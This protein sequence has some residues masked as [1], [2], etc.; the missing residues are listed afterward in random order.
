MSGLNNALIGPLEADLGVNISDFESLPQGQLTFAISQN[1][2]DG[3]ND[4]P[5]GMIFLLD[6]GSKKDLLKTNL[7]GL[8]KKWKDSGKTIRTQTIRGV[9]FSIVM[10][11]S[12]DIPGALTRTCSRRRHRLKSWA[13]RRSRKSRTNWSSANSILY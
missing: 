11:S 1:G 6:A 5:Q 9:P 8:E 12:N 4:S 3:T 7:A 13:R 10:I 2:W